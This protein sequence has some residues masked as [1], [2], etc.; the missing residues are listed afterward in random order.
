MLN[1]DKSCES[2]LTYFGQHG[3]VIRRLLPLPGLYINPRTHASPN[4]RLSNPHVIDPQSEVATKCACAIV[5]PRE[6]ST[7][8]SVQTKRIGEAPVFD[9]L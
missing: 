7:S 2:C 5:P 3:R 9:V 1:P 6:M 8:V 4:Q